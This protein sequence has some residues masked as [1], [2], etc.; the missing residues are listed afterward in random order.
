MAFRPRL[1]AGLALSLLLPK[2]STD[3][4]VVQS[5][6]LIQ[7]L[8]GNQQCPLWVLSGPFDQYYLKVRFRGK[9]DTFS[10]RIDDF[11]GPQSAKRGH[12]VKIKISFVTL[13]GISVHY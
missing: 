2:R 9:A 7:H 10:P 5:V 4:Q 1:S 13:P 11:K 3:G 12:S 8:L 6:N